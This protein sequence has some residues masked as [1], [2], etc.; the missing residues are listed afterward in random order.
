MGEAQQIEASRPSGARR[1]TPLKPP[2][3]S[4]E[5]DQAS[6]LRVE[7]Q[8]IARKPLREDFQHPASIGLKR[9]DQDGVIGVAHQKGR[10]FQ[11]RQDLLGEPPI[12]DSRPVKRVVRIILDASTEF[13]EAVRWYEKQRSGLGTE[14]F[15]E[16]SAALEISQLAPSSEPL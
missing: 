10:P 5:T 8:T 6:L 15:D 11:S 14:F 2:G 16:V 3:G 12:Q 7:P 4:Q 13:S 9:E 1:L